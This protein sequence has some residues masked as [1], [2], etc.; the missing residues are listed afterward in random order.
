MEINFSFQTGY[1]YT[2]FF[3]VKPTYDQAARTGTFS[4]SDRFHFI[5]VTE[6]WIL[7]TPDAQYCKSCSLK[8][9]FRYVHVPFQT[10]FPVLTLQ[11]IRSLL[12]DTISA[13][14]FSREKAGEIWHNAIVERHYIIAKR[15]HSKAYFSLQQR[16]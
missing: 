5:Q 13:F 11:I 12:T 3:R 10:G 16:R 15:S 6:M 14:A 2:Y 8:R 7:V 4:F 9:G 1:G